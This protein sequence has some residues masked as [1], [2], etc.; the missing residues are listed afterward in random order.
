MDNTVVQDLAILNQLLKELSALYKSSISQAGVPESEFWILYALL[1]Y[2]QDYTQHDLCT[3]WSLPKQTANTIISSLARKGLIELESIPQSRNQKR[4]CL[5]P[6][7]IG[8]AENIVLPVYEAEQKAL[9][10]IPA[11]SRQL[12]WSLLAG[13]IQ[14][15]GKEIHKHAN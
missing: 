5:T 9:G 12:V 11:A 2:G 7:G 6:A 15:L 10:Q 8:Y 3:L 4:I 1:L 14:G 13:Y